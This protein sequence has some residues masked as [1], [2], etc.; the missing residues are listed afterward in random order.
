M[1]N[2]YIRHEITRLTT[3]LALLTKWS[4]QDLADIIQD[5]GFSCTLCGR[6][7][8]TEFNG[9]VFLL[10]DDAAR[11]KK[12]KPEVL[13]PAP[14]FEL[15]DGEGNFYV[16]GYALRVR[17]DGTCVFLENNRCAIYE[18]RFAIC[19]IYPYMLH[20]EPD[21]KKNPVFRQISGLNEHGDY[22]YP[23]SEDEAYAL[24]EE[25][26]QYENAWLMQMID[27]YTTAEERFLKNNTSHIRKNYDRRIQEFKKGASVQVY[28][29]FKGD[30]VP[31]IVRREEYQGF[32]WP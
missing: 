4:P 11:I 26:I 13:V 30:F 16:S 10:D 8:T 27:F 28:V 24:A 21:R 25:T 14:E 1:S 29:W 17:E 15:V 7:C 23:I 19:R 2:S 12:I 3:E 22:H 9:H 6:C 32:G 20:R 18:N 31:V 5:V